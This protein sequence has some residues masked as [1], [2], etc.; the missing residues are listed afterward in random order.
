MNETDADGFD[1]KPRRLIQLDN[2]IEWK[3]GSKGGGGGGGSMKGG[4]AWRVVV[5]FPIPSLRQKYSNWDLF[6]GP[7]SS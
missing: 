4:R 2:R 3:T 1:K 6:E 7:V 5:I